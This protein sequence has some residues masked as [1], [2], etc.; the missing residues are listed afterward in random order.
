M[1][2]YATRD[3]KMETI[4]RSIKECD[5]FSIPAQYEAIIAACGKFWGTRRQSAQEL[6]KA[7]IADEIIVLDGKDVWTY[8]RWEKIKEA[9]S[10]DYLRMKDKI[11]NIFQCSLNN[12]L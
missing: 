10:L 11:N 6:I 8:E 3:I 4:L 5:R 2:E 1:K 9:R 12:E 7:L